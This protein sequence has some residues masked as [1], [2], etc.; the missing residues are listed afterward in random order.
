MSAPKVP[1]EPPVSYPKGD[2]TDQTSLSSA[3]TA[4]LPLDPFQTAHRKMYDF[5]HENQT[6]AKGLGYLGA[7][8]MGGLGIIGE[9]A[10]GWWFGTA[11]NL[12]RGKGLEESFKKSFSTM[13]GPAVACYNMIKEANKVLNKQEQALPKTVEQIET[14]VAPPSK[15]EEYVKSLITMGSP[16]R[17]AAIEFLSSRKHYLSA[18]YPY[19]AYVLKKIDDGYERVCIGYFKYKEI[20]QKLVDL[21]IQMKNLKF[22]PSPNPNQAGY[23]MSGYPY[24]NSVI[25][26]KVPNISDSQNTQ[27]PQQSQFF[28]ENFSP[29][30][31]SK[32]NSDLLVHINPFDVILEYTQTLSSSPMISSS[33]TTAQSIVAPK[34]PPDPEATKQKALASPKTLTQEERDVLIHNYRNDERNKEFCVGAYCNNAY[35]GI[36]CIGYFRKGDEAL[37]QK[38]LDYTIDTLNEQQKHSFPGDQ[39][40]L[41]TPQPLD[42]K[43]RY[44]LNAEVTF[45]QKHYK[46][47]KI[48]DPF[49]PS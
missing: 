27:N 25:L 22:G 20:A 16:D 42:T 21:T 12:A 11:V 29:E 2:T 6:A 5:A 49:N 36:Y 14:L 43:N 15:E 33:T 37:A 18:E 7:F 19:A 44:R 3:D 1:S 32:I 39:N 10:V 45:P 48:I 30:E 46:I 13:M 41:F 23:Y 47:T 4:S 31:S 9:I 26:E 24:V 8:V 35:V 17:E 28:H 40:R 38:L 34:T